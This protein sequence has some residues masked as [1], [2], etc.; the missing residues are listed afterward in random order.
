[1]PGDRRFTVERDS[2]G[3]IV[4]VVPGVTQRVCEPHARRLLAQLTEA[5]AGPDPIVCPGCYAVDALCLP[6]CIDAEIAA[7][8]EGHGDGGEDE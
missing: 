4:I 8:R 3:A 5:L 2:D 6:G 1:V 7:E